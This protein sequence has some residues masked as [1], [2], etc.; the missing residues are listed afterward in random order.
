MENKLSEARAISLEMV[1]HCMNF[2]DLTI[3]DRREIS[4]KGG[5][6]KRDEHL[7]WAW[8]NQNKLRKEHKKLGMTALAKKYNLSLRST[9]R[10][11]RGK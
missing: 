10:V 7:V 1:A 4:S 3:E 6:A 5:L 9:Y 2:K 8:A 11:V